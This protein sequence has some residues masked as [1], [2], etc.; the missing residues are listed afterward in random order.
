[1]TTMTVKEFTASFHSDV[2]TDATAMDILLEHAFVEKFS[3]ILDD[4]GEF[5]NFEPSHWQ[6]RGI[7]IDGYAFDD[8]FTVVTLVVSHFL[9]CNDIEEA[10]V[11][12]SEID[13]VFKR[14]VNFFQKSI[15]GKLKDK[16]EVSNPAQELASLIYECRKS[17][18][19]ARIIVITDGITR[20]RHAED[21][22]IEGVA[23]TKVVWDIQRTKDFVMTGEREHITIDFEGDYDSPIKCVESESSCGSYSAFLAFVPGQ[24]LADLYGKW[25]IRL[26]ERNV[27]VFLSQRV[28]VNQG[29]R[30]TIRDEPTLFCA[31]NNGITVYAK[32]VDLID[33]ASGEQAIS[34]V[35]DFQIVN[36]GQTTASLYHTREKFGADLTHVM[37]QMKLF[38]ID[39]DAN[40]EWF[41]DDDRLSDILLPRIGR[42]SNTQ[43]Q[44]QM[45]DLLANDPPHPEL[46]AISLNCP[47]PDPTGGSVQ[48]FW[49]YEKSRGSYEETRRLQAKT[50]AQKRKFDQKYPKKQRFDKNKFG[51]AWNS[52][53]KQPHVVCLGAM[54]NFAR[55]NNWM[56]E[57]ENE[58]WTAFFRK[59]VALIKLWNETE[60]I[61]RK[62]KFGG[63]THAIVSYTL[64]WFHHSTGLKLDLD[65]IWSKQI[66]DDSVLE[67]IEIMAREVNKHIRKTKLNVTEWC[68]KEDCWKSLLEFE[69]DGLPDMKDAM[70]SGRRSKKY[71]S[72]AK[73]EEQDLDFCKTK[74]GEAWKELSKWLK[75]RDFMQGK[76]RSQCFNM[77]RTL[78]QGKKEPSAV[79]CVVCKKIWLTAEESYGWSPSN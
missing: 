72:P 23:V 29:I 28:K 54:K 42:F 7:K 58:D 76:Q 66:I 49:F 3:E 52:Y 19:S 64:A 61:V 60:R 12:N 56:Q 79:L 73:S 6:D 16:I 55:F 25:K 51:K 44:I 11:T 13:K 62:Q 74:G 31:Y 24:V 26:L 77:G 46:N 37:V 33:L 47:A 8:E 53:R 17:I 18:V 2:K 78:E 68:K 22:E 45:A 41:K 65:K 38:V 32:E 50:L 57:L 1:M 21:D 75:D 39:D 36:G 5:D 63:Y 67:A 48:S 4:Y 15:Q 34:S 14:G 20:E 69:M 27:R 35:R 43:N 70:I 71:D 40:P 9:N 10:N 59:T 30:N